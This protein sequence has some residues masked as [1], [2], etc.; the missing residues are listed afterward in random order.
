VGSTIVKII[1]FAS[2]MMV[3]FDFHATEVGDLA[4]GVIHYRFFMKTTI[5]IKIK[6]GADGRRWTII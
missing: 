5:W 6:E 1:G 2:M 3:G 4:V